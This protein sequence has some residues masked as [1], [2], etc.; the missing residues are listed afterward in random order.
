M[1]DNT[2]VVTGVSWFHDKLLEIMTDRLE[3]LKE[4]IAEGV[5]TDEY[6]QMVGRY[7]ETKR[8][9]KIT[10]PELFEEFYQAEESVADDGELE[11]LTDEQ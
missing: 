11:E 3:H 1:G 6:R 2:E 8:F 5:P 9:V 4:G 7:K 10:L